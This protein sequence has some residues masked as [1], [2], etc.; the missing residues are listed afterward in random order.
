MNISM[1]FA[2]FFQDDKP[3]DWDRLF[4]EVSSELRTEWEKAAGPKE[5]GDGEPVSINTSA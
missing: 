3:W 4:T 2:L 1:C 5:E